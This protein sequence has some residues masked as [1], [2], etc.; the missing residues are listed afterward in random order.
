VRSLRSAEAND[1]DLDVAIRFMD[2]HGN[3]W[4]RSLDTVKL[5][6]RA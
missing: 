6:K 2:A 1:D 5:V 4:L 3:R